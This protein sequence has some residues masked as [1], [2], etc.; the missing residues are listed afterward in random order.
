MSEARRVYSKKY[1]DENREAIL[2]YR[3]KYY[4]DNKFRF[5]EICGEKLKYG[6]ITEHKRSHDKSVP[7]GIRNKKQPCIIEI[8]FDFSG[9]I[10]A[11][12]CRS[13]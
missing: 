8:P 4:Y 7:K 11:L 10:E 6:T 12:N 9:I 3:K 2:E 5:C 13:P 1:Y